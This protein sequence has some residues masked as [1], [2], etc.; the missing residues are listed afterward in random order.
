MK[1]LPEQIERARKYYA[2]VSADVVTR[3]ASADEDF[4]MTIGNR[5]CTGKGARGDAGNARATVV[6]LWIDDLTVKVRG[7][8]RGFEV[9]SRGSDMNA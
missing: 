8:F 3:D 1:S 7:S 9:L 2:A 6:L 4:A 5:V